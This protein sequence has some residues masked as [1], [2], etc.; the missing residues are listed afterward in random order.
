MHPDDGS[1]WTR[2][3]LDLR[4]QGIHEYQSAPS[5]FVSIGLLPAAGICDHHRQTV[6]IA[7]SSHHDTSM[8]VLHCV[9]HCLVRR[10]NDSIT[11]ARVDFLSSKPIGERPTQRS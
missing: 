7:R 4:H 6:L 10:E 3:D 1:I 9:R 5:G 11:R 8:S 2:C